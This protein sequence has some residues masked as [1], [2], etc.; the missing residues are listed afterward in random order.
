MNTFSPRICT[1]LSQLKLTQLLHYEH[2]LWFSGIFDTLDIPFSL[3]TILQNVTSHLSLMTVWFQQRNVS[4]NV[5]INH[6]TYVVKC[7]KFS[8]SVP[9]I[10]LISFCLL[11]GCKKSW[12]LPPTCVQKTKDAINTWLHRSISKVSMSNNKRKL[13]THG[14]GWSYSIKFI[15]EVIVTGCEIHFNGNRWIWWF[16]FQCYRILNANET[17]TNFCDVGSYIETY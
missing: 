17:I 4:M 14:R 8:N 15:W 13:E 16:T 2:N 7:G 1:E 9:A 11:L 10:N 3:A 5:V 12:N 6:F